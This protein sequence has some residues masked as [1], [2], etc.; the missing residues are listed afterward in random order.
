MDPATI[1]G[2]TSAILS[3]VEFTGKIISTA[4]E[5]HKSLDGATNDNLTLEST[6]ANFEKVFKDVQSKISSTPTRS[7][8]GTSTNKDNFARDSL[9]QTLAKCQSLGER[10]SDL[11]QKTKAV[12]ASRLSMLDHLDKWRRKHRK[13]HQVNQTNSGP[14]R[15]TLVE[16]MRATI[17]TVWHKE[18][19]NDLREEWEVCLIQFKIDFSKQV[20]PLISVENQY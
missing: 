4:V 16:V 14:V 13:S 5:I 7:V 10:I 18:E 17:R 1:I 3:F 12:P 19:L 20:N 11:L 8:A 2:T 6:V 15:P 9:I